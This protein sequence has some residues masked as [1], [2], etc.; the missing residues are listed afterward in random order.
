MRASN[1]HPSIGSSIII[2]IIII[3]IIVV[4]IGSSNEE[5]RTSATS[6]AQ[7]ERRRS[8]IAF[9]LNTK[10]LPACPTGPKSAKAFGRGF[11]GESEEG[12]GWEDG[13]VEP[14]VE[15]DVLCARVHVRAQPHRQALSRDVTLHVKCPGLRLPDRQT[16]SLKASGP[17]RFQRKSPP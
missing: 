17:G 5:A 10:H 2:I 1:H 8:R 3:I 16:L 14:R 15:L 11:V 13:V 4:I 6:S 7:T 9:T 12:V